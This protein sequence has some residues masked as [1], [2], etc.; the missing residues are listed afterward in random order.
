[1]SNI[2]ALPRGRRAAPAVFPSA[3]SGGG[4]VHARTTST[5]THQH[6]PAPAFSSADLLCFHLLSTCSGAP[7]QSSPVATTLIDSTPIP[8]PRPIPHTAP[9]DSLYPSLLR[10]EPRL[11]HPGP[12][13]P[14]RGL[15]PHCS[16]AWV[17][18][19][20]APHRVKKWAR[21]TQELGWLNGHSTDV[22]FLCLH[23]PPWWLSRTTRCARRQQRRPR[24]GSWRAWAP[25]RSWPS[26]CCRRSGASWHLRHLC[27][28]RSRDGSCRGEVRSPK[29]L[30]HN[31][32]KSEKAVPT[33]QRALEGSRGPVASCYRWG[34]PPSKPSS[35]AAPPRPQQRRLDTWPPRAC[36]IELLSEVFRLYTN[37]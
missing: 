9:T 5:H 16:P 12:V 19:P 22:P 29:L 6:P 8:H 24:W 3:P 21:E 37:L 2:N 31:F 34:T 17:H 36:F 11:P 33:E 14:M 32:R 13:L 23:S 26:W 30:K 25:R 4:G 10:T 35:K 15:C 28:P 27:L 18:L 7:T 20:W 1:M